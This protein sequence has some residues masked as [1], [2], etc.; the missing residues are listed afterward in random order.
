MED[1][2]TGIFS[3]FMS[4]RPYPHFN[5]PSSQLFPSYSWGG[6]M[7]ATGCS[8]IRP[9]GNRQ[10]SGCVTAMRGRERPYVLNGGM[11]HCADPQIG[12]LVKYR[13]VH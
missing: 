1:G 7:W 3:P 12:W 4:F 6:S 5:S 2:Q 13:G 9:Q 11:F 8:K 10:G